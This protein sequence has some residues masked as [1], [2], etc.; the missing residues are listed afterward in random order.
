MKKILVIGD[1]CKDVYIYGKCDRLCPDAPVPVFIPKYEVKTGGMAQNV[2]NNVIDLGACC[3]L[4][5]NQKEI[6]K[7]RYVDDKTNQMLVRVDVGENE[8]DKIDLKNIDLGKYCAIIL[9]DYDKGFLSEED[10]QFF[11]QNHDTV[12][13]DTKR[14]LGKYIKDAKFIKLNEFEYKQSKH[15]IDTLNLHN[16][17]LITV[18]GDGC[19]YKEENYPVKK[20]DIKDQTGA[21]DTFTAAF[22]IKFIVT[23]D[24]PT[25]IKYANECATKVVQK[26]GVTTIKQ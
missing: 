21:G 16:Q 17:L 14:L 6:V 4:L 24:I 18:G 15:I 13:I 9:S 11:C 23:G 22:T 20:V 2:Y 3:H 12:I 7:T 26:R 10:I 1:S 8:V 5:T 25:S 19:N